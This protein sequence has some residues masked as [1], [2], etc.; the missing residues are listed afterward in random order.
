[1]NLVKYFDAQERLDRKVI[2]VHS[3]QDR[4]LTADVTTALHVELGELAQEIGFFKYWKL[5]KRND[6]ARQFDEWADVL[7]FMLSLGNKY[8]HSDHID[9]VKSLGYLDASL[10]ELFSELYRADFSNI[11]EYAFAFRALLS[12]GEH[13]G[14]DEAAMESSYFSKMQTNYDRLASGY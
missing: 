8:G 3:L 14:M 12:I 2:E 10:N 11:R 5:N 4:N 6:K 9:E 1:M 7:H 13:I